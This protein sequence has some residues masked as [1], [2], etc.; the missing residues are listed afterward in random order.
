MQGVAADGLRRP[1][2][3]C[4]VS[5]SHQDRMALRWATGRAIPPAPAS[6]RSTE[7]QC[8]S[9][10]G[11]VRRDCA[12]RDSDH[13]DARSLRRPES[14]RRQ[15]ESRG[16]IHG[17]WVRSGGDPPFLPVGMVDVDFSTAMVL[18]GWAIGW[19]LLAVLS[20]RSPSNLAL[21]RG[22]ANF[23]TMSGALVLLAPD[24]VV[25]AL[26]WVWPPALLVLVAWVWTR[27]RRE[28]HSRTRVWL[29]NPV[30]VILGSSPRRG[31]RDDQPVHRPR[32][33]HAWSA[34]RRRTEPT[35]P[36]ALAHAVRP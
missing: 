19:A 12:K 31:L 1:P 23:M 3:T 26:G 36:S 2:A 34:R 20:T 6:A 30:L 29:L 24:A 28:L 10:R 32:G 5:S 27:A 11:G 33:L 9:A 7:T 15:R 18:F 25:D 4:G 14:R 17:R 22:A 35:P 16:R 13:D 21:G 8:A